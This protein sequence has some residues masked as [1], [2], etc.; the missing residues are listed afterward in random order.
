MKSL[1]ESMAY[2]LVEKPYKETHADQQLL[3]KS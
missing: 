1:K 3:T 2:I